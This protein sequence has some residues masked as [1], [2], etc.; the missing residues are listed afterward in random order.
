MS[1]SFL[2][3]VWLYDFTKRHNC[4]TAKRT[5][6]RF[7]QNQ[8]FISWHSH[9]QNRWKFH[10]IYPKLVKNIWK[11]KFITFFWTWCTDTDRRRATASTRASIFRAGIQSILWKQTKPELSGNDSKSSF[12]VSPVAIEILTAV[13]TSLK[14]LKIY[15]F[16]AQCYACAVYAVVL[17]LSVSLSVCLSVC[18]SVTSQCSTKTA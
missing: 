4:V 8:I 14:H 11:N 12:V 5:F 13:F 10:K 6:S 2:E 7:C 17:C 16:T 1:T 9:L 15:I 18:P 3:G